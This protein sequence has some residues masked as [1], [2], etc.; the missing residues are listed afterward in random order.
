MKLLFGK[1]APLVVAAIVLVIS[2]LAVGARGQS[3][4]DCLEICLAKYSACVG[5]AGVNCDVEFELCSEA[6]LAEVE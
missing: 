5:A 2:M 6:C 4:L 3:A 1:K